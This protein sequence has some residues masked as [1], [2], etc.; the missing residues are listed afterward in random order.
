MKKENVLKKKY[1]ECYKFFK[2]SKVY[3]LIA[4]GIFV[5]TA[6]IGFIFPIFFRDKIFEIVAEMTQMFEG[7]SGLE[8][9]F[10]IFFNNIKA[11]FFSV[12]LGIGLGLFPIIAGVVNGYILGFVSREVVNAEGFL[13]L[14]QLLP[15]GIFE[16][17]AIL[18]SI[19][20]GLKLGSN[21]MSK[22][23]KKDL[24]KDSKSAL[25]FFCFVIFPLLLVAA[26]IEGL[27]MVLL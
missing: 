8:T 21:L 4:V 26:I 13:V 2:E 18:M 11:S 15:H 25:K 20:I 19:G 24:E 12:V 1:F 5:F 23:F 16:I 6:V 22:N 7:K 10:M 3:I 17:P 27:L 9:I 14:W